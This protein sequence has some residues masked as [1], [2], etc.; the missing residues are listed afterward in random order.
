MLPIIYFCLWGHTLEQGWSTRSLALTDN[1][2]SQPRTY[3]LVYSSSAM[4]G[5]S[6]A[7]PTLA[8]KLTV[9]IWQA[10]VWVEVHSGPAISRRRLCSSLPWS[11]LWQSCSVT[12]R[13]EWAGFS[14]QQFYFLTAGIMVLHLTL[15]IARFSLSALS[16]FIKDLEYNQAKFPTLAKSQVIFKIF[17]LDLQ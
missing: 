7:L 5:G 17:N 8:R 11:R 16:L 4:D 13:V 9:L 2:V 3:Q 14:R 15:S 1:W 6:G 12:L 10:T